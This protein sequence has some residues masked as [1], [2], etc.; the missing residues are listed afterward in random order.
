[1]YLCHLDNRPEW[2]VRRKFSDFFLFQ[3]ALFF[4]DIEFNLPHSHSLMTI[5]PRCGKIYVKCICIPVST[6]HSHLSFGCVHP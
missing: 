3:N 6:P 4:S 2:R 1:M 5:I